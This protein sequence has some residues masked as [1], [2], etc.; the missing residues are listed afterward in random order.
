MLEVGGE[1][2]DP[3]FFEETK[4]RLTD[5]EIRL[6]LEQSERE[7]QDRRWENRRRSLREGFRCW[8]GAQCPHCQG[9][10]AW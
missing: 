3:P 4:M 2:V 8:A 9:E 5:D 6:A 1:Y 10:V 7:D